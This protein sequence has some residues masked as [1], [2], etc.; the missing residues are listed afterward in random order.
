MVLNIST[1]PWMK[2]N[3]WCSK[4]WSKAEIVQIIVTPAYTH[5]LDSCEIFVVSKVSNVIFSYVLKCANIIGDV[6]NVDGMKVVGIS[7]A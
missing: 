4:A 5:D 3:V 7:K 6:V 1:Y 2:K